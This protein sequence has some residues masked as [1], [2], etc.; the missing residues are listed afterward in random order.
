LVL[1]IVTRGL[2]AMVKSN[3]YLI[4]K[5]MKHL[6]SQDLIVCLP[7]LLTL[8]C[9]II[10]WFTANS[11]GIKKYY[12]NKFNS[13]EA[14][15]KHVFF[16]KILGL[17]VFGGLPFIISSI[18]LKGSKYNFFGIQIV[19][20]K[21]LFS[22]LWTLGLSLVVIPLAFR[23]AKNPK[24]LINYPQ[25]RAKIWTRKTFVINLFGWAIYLFGY[26]LLFRGILFFPLAHELGLW[27]AITINIALYSATHIPKGLDETIGAIPLGIVL[28]LLTWESEMIWI[29][30]FVH[31]AMAWTNS[32]T[33]LKFHP[34]IKY[35]NWN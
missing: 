28:C 32:L 22:F 17:I 11:T 16:T 19:F 31:L 23:S 26:E 8:F 13:D 14:S 29:A 3:E 12:F 20:N 9:F 33:A 30:Y 7:I 2:K 5:I 24:N 25:I 21:V 10:Y 35:K 27:Q 6:S 1:A 15:I 34:E 18:F 4:N